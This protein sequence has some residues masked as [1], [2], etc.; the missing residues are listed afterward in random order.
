MD[1]EEKVKHNWQTDGISE[2]KNDFGYVLNHLSAFQKHALVFEYISNPSFNLSCLNLVYFSSIEDFDSPKSKSATSSIHDEKGEKDTKVVLFLRV[3]VKIFEEM[4][5]DDETSNP[6][7]AKE[8]I[9]KEP[10]MPK[11]TP[12]EI[13][14]A[15]MVIST[16]YIPEI[17][18]AKTTIPIETA[19]EGPQ[20]SKVSIS[21]VK[22]EA[23]KEM[24]DIQ[25]TTT[26]TMASTTM[27]ETT[28][29]PTEA[30]STT[31]ILAL[32]SPHMPKMTMQ[33]SPEDIPKTTLSMTTAGTTPLISFEVP[34]LQKI[35]IPQLPSKP[36]PTE[37]SSTLPPP[38]NIL[39][40]ATTSKPI[41]SIPATPVFELSHMDDY[42]S[43][44]WQRVIGGI[45]CSMKDC[46]GVLL[47]TIS[48]DRREIQNLTLTRFV[49][50]HGL[51]PCPCI[52]MKELQKAVMKETNVVF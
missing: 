16:T 11:I 33:I 46:A 35:N 36:I 28:P 25:T 40:I 6:K 7:Y 34:N 51:P 1:H 43:T 21:E 26:T 38:T 15:P 41:K 3:L 37:P 45:R 9:A 14:E 18:V 8:V 39:P 12:V 29:E 48:Y 23:T 5:S 24:E 32:D 17:D 49:R 52:D 10:P 19:I 42:E 44:F 4:F 27:M 2:E 31:Q 50:E 47:P 13:N 22:P 20:I 30:T